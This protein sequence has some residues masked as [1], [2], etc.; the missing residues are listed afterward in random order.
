[1][2]YGDPQRVQR[3]EAMTQ[4]EKK[5]S[6]LLAKIKDLERRLEEAEETLLAIRRG[7]VDGVV[8][9]G[10]QG[11]QLFLLRGAEHAY[12][13][14]VE[15]M[16]EGA[17]T[18]TFDGTILYCN[19]RFSDMVETPKET[20][21]G[22][23]MFQYVL[24]ADAFRSALEKARGSKEKL[25]ALLRRGGQDTLPAYISLTPLVENEIPAICAVITDLGTLKQSEQQLRQLTSKLLS[26]HEEERKRM[27]GDIHDGLGSYL[28][29]IKMTAEDILEKVTRGA[30]DELLEP[31]KSMLRTAQESIEECRRLQMDLRPAMLDDLGILPTLSW[32][33]RKVQTAYPG[34]RIEQTIGIQ[35]HEV[36]DSLKTVIFRITQEAVNNIAKHSKADLVSLALTGS[37]DEIELTI[38]D[39]GTGFDVRETLGTEKFRRGLGLESMRER[40]ELSGGTLTLESAPG[41][42]TVVRASWLVKGES[43]G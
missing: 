12:H 23:S 13:V 24:S 31:V 19:D 39:N 14:F 21:I 6:Q 2:E 33:C 32:W 37:K 43:L 30:K 11:D 9:T 22:G 10:P 15:A 4:T 36:P 1:L 16:N 40:A 42:G 28:S 5:N 29:H 27:A 17:V 20:V 25:E 34:L 8:V 18:L 3:F 26:A 41:R 38:A 35:E 7:E